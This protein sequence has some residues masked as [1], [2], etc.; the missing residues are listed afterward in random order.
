MGTLSTIIIISVVI[1]VCVVGVTIIQR[2]EQEKARIRQLVSKYR[3]RANETANILSNFANTPIG[4]EARMLM[5]NYIILNLKQALKLI[6]NDANLQTSIE[7]LTLQASNASSP[8]DSQRLN[9][10]KDPNQLA[11][12]ISQLSKLGKYLTRFKAIPAL[13][14]NMVA[15]AV[16]KL[17][18]LISEAKICAY[19]QQGQN[20]LATH[21]YVRSQ[22]LFQT[23]QQMLN[24]FTKKNSRLETLE[25]ELQALIK[26]TPMEA[27]NRTLSIE[28][29]EKG[30]EEESADIFGPKKKW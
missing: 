2:R 4:L 12:L 8:I 26:A 20:S 11:Q 7:N 30:T 24:K 23:A 28:N 6:P 9:I 21:D 5:L 16:S 22:G 29:E 15:I 18:L 1:L 13:D 19:I 27:A 14:E 3:Y 17:S 25:Q 10:P